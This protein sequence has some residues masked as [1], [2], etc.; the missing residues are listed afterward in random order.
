MRKV[1]QKG[2][3]EDGFFMSESSY[4]IFLNY[5]VALEVSCS[6]KNKGFVLQ[7]SHDLS[8]KLFRDGV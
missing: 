1:A 7:S 5:I 8:N 2:K 4:V 6:S 3:F